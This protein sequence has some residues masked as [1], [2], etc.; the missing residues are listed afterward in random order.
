ML[1]SAIKGL[2]RI[3]MEEEVL[4]GLVFWGSSFQNPTSSIIWAL[5]VKRKGSNQRVERK[6]GRETVNTSCLFLKL[7]V[8]SPYACYSL[9]NFV[10]FKCFWV[11][12]ELGYVVV[13]RGV[14]AGGEEQKGRESFEQSLWDSW[15][16]AEA[17]CLGLFSL[18]MLFFFLQNNWQ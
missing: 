9:P 7:Y 11:V 6:I 16:T 8:V 13:A 12:R 18:T 2:N 4:R 1:L 3:R 17:D 10:P 15:A 14:S 5:I